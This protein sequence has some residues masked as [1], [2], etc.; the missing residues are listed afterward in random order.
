MVQAPIEPLVQDLRIK[1][2]LNSKIVVTPI[3]YFGI[4]ESLRGPGPNVR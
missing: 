1:T 3:A 4:G 2:R